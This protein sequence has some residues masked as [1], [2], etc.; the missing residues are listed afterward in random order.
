MRFKIFY[1]FFV[2][3]LTG[4]VRNEYIENMPVEKRMV[5][6]A[7]TDCEEDTKTTLDGEVGS[8][9]RKVLWDVK[10]SIGIVSQQGSSFNKFVNIQTEESI[11]GLFEGMYSGGSCYAVYPYNKNFKL[12]G[13]TINLSLPEVQE[14]EE[15]SF[16]LNC[17]PM[18]ARKSTDEDLKFKNL[19]GVLVL[20][21]TGNFSVKSI[22][23]T[24]KDSNGE[25]IRVSGGATVD[26]AYIRTPELIM[27]ADASTKVVLDCNSGVQLNAAE[28]VPFHIVLPVGT[29]NTFSVVVAST[30]GRIY[31]KEGTKPLTI[32]R[33]IATKSSDF[34]PSEEQ[35]IDL[36]LRGTSNCY[37]VSKRGAYS[38]DASVIGNG[39][40]GI[41]DKAIF[42]TDTPRIELENAEILWVDKEPMIS[43][44]ILDNTN[45][46]VSFFY[47]GDEGNGVIAL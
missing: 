8:V 29:Y 38:F 13:T 35:C 47:N 6:T 16:G 19:C 31:I 5:I 23:F 14:Y 10:D 27:A 28:S 15:N 22:T 11:K 1:L 46:R 39:E 43:S 30:D 12:Q 25:Y 4:C 24:A 20:R 37:I 3:L 26:M 17:S 33:S 40:S 9:A 44:V 2:I 7:Y 34:T 21:M 32:K 42:H 41:I 36:S 45:N 18:V